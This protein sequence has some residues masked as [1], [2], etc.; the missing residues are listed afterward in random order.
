M[1][2]TNVLMHVKKK[3]YVKDN[4][5]DKDKAKII[6]HSSHKAY[7]KLMFLT[8]LFE[9]EDNVLVDTMIKELKKHLLSI[10]A[11]ISYEVL[12]P[13]YNEF[14]EIKK[15]IALLE[16]ALPFARNH[17][18]QFLKEIDTEEKA[19][20][21]IYLT[22]SAFNDLAG[23]LIPHVISTNENEI[24]QVIT[25]QSKKIILN[26]LTPLF[27]KFPNFKNELDEIQTTFG[28]FPY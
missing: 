14:P 4:S 22:T 28:S 25:E 1:N 19:R 5:M 24:T 26:V 16:T 10:S 11:R 20:I 3:R 9:V 17:K 18:T 21:V 6:A 27:K 7:T 15:D 12:Y 23:R 8:S 13:I 2:S